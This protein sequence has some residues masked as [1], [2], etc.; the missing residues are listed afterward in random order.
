MN[1]TWWNSQMGEG[2]PFAS[3]VFPFMLIGIVVLSMMLLSWRVWLIFGAVT[4]LAM[5]T[6]MPG[7]RK[8][9]IAEQAA[10]EIA[11]PLSAARGDQ[12]PQMRTDC[13]LYSVTGLVRR[14]FR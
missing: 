11:C 9:F 6:V 7:V 10:L 8:P 3:Y 13:Q 5:L 2:I 1:S 14:D 4:V 12:T